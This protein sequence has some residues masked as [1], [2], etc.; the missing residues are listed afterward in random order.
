[1]PQLDPTWY[2]SQL[3][4]LLIT[5]SFLY[6]VVRHSLLPQIAEVMETRSQRMASELD[7]AKELKLEADGAE[8]AYKE[9]LAHARQSA[10]SS[11]DKVSSRISRMR[12][13]R[14][15]QLDEK[16]AQQLAEAE[17]RIASMRAEVIEQMRE[18]AQGLAVD[19]VTRMTGGTPTQS[20]VDK[21]MK[22]AGE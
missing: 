18:A 2:A 5:F 8:K 1:M 14:H 22:A 16:L 20:T 6:Y 19:I 12:V 13:E 17:S 3:F 11:M 15:E 10:N 21:A 9:A 4:W 7:R